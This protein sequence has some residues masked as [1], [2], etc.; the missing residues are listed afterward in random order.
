MILFQRLPVQNRHNWERKFRKV[1]SFNKI[2]SIAVFNQDDEFSDCYLTTLGVDFV[3]L[4]ILAIQVDSNK[5]Q[6]YKDLNRNLN[7]ISGTQQDK[8][9]SEQLQMLITEEPMVNLL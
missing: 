8:R 1:F 9:D 2:F 3:I 6:K 4:I 5:R 7:Y